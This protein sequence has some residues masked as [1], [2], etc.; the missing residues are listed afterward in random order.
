M[1]PTQPQTTQTAIGSDMRCLGTLVTVATA[2]AVLLLA[3]APAMA[4]A[5]STKEKK[6]SG[7]PF[8]R[9]QHAAGEREDKAAPG[10]EKPKYKHD[11]R[12]G[13]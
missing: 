2:A 7:G 3:P 6:G 1:P 8:Q 12:R 11:A 13:E 4:A 5:V 10:A 9:F